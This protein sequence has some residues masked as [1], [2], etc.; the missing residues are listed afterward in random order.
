MEFLINS[1]PIIELSLIT[2]SLNLD[3]QTSD[4]DVLAQYGYACKQLG[5]EIETSSVSQAK[6]LIERTNS[7]FQATFRLMN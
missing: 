5:I 2:M 3:K 6:G 1:L 7:T 4:K